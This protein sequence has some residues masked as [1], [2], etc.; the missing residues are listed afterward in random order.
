MSI[1]CFILCS[2]LLLQNENTSTLYNR[3]S[4]KGKVACIVNYGQ[5]QSDSI[6]FSYNKE[7]LLT[8]YRIFKDG[9]ADGYCE[10]KYSSN[11]RM[12]QYHYDSSGKPQVHCILEYDN[13]KNLTMIREYGYIYPD[14]TKMTL[15]YLR[16]NSYNTENRIESAFEYFCDGSPSYRYKYSY[17][18]DCTI[19]QERIN[20][21]TGEIFTI[22][23]TTDDKFGSTIKVCEIMPQDSPEWQNATIDYQYD[24]NGNWISRKVN[25]CDPRIMNAATNATRRIYYIEQ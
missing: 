17:E 11:N 9:K 14:T 23:R 16:C 18:N 13:S 3:E 22:T 20:A 12:D 4:L 8:G 19:T 7:N 25:G 10:Y 6:V 1:F 2:C 5:W 15:L 21:T 24:N